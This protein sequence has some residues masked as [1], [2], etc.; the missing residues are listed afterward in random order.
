[1]ARLGEADEFRT[2]TILDLLRADVKRGGIAYPYH[3]LYDSLKQKLGGTSAILRRPSEEV[4]LAVVQLLV[5]CMHS[6]HATVTETTQGAIQTFAEILP[7]VAKDRVRR[8]CGVL[9]SATLKRGGVRAGVEIAK[10][11]AGSQG[12]GNVDD[13]GTARR[14]NA[15]RAI[16]ILVDI[17]Y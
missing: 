6:G 4:V 12:V 13:V 3:L 11:I 8:A 9:L 1:M 15:R 14:Q 17:V 7:F 16:G 10:I 5:E 2:L